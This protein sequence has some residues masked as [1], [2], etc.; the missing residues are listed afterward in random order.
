MCNLVSNNIH[1]Y[2]AINNQHSAEKTS[3]TPTSP[4]DE[5]ESIFIPLEIVLHIFSFLSMYDLNNK[6]SLVCKKW[7][8]LF[9]ESFEIWKKFLPKEFVVKQERDYREVCLN[10]LSIGNNLKTKDY[11]YR[12]MICPFGGFYTCMF[13][14]KDKIFLGSNKGFVSIIDTQS[15]HLISSVCVKNDEPIQAIAICED[16]LVVAT[17]EKKFFAAEKERDTIGSM[18]HSVRGALHFFSISKMDEPLYVT[19]FD[20]VVD[21]IKIHYFQTAE[22]KTTAI[23]AVHT[24]QTLNTTQTREDLFLFNINGY[25]LSTDREGNPTPCFKKVSSIYLYGSLLFCI[26]EHEDYKYLSCISIKNT[27]NFFIL[28]TLVNK[29]LPNNITTETLIWINSLDDINVGGYESDITSMTHNGIKKSFIYKINLEELLEKKDFPTCPI[30]IPG[31]LSKIIHFSK[32]QEM[33]LTEHSDC[34][35]LNNSQYQIIF[36][37]NKKI[38]AW[39]LDTYTYLNIKPRVGLADGKIFVLGSKHPTQHVDESLAL[40]CYDFKDNR[41][42]DRLA[43]Q[44]NWL[45]G[46]LSFISYL[47]H[48]KKW[49]ISGPLVLASLYFSSVK[50]CFSLTHQYNLNHYAHFGMTIGLCTGLTLLGYI[51]ALSTRLIYDKKYPA[52]NTVI[53]AMC[54][55]PLVFLRS[56]SSFAKPYMN[57]IT[58]EFFVESLNSYL[59]WNIEKIREENKEISLSIRELELSTKQFENQI[60]SISRVSIRNPI[61]FNGQWFERSYLLEFLEYSLMI[62]GK[63]PS[64]INQSDDTG[65]KEQIEKSRTFTSKVEK[66]EN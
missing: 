11:S 9:S 30:T 57:F 51:Y 54:T 35:K 1:D 33:F 47:L 2:F 46:Q 16:R 20:H 5:T 7:K 56:R 34:R 15:M 65:L 37:K 24:R 38:T 29:L 32:Q 66:K 26:R 53:K 22:L 17:I 12:R 60:C 14:Y 44:I 31:N 49:A 6:A 27:D 4:L 59:L 8:Q 43:S 3:I 41:H 18:Y 40:D 52:S 55:L 62:S 39:N 58:Q 28:D 13:T 45:R 19:P 21:S 36:L 63:Y 42:L 48:E 64:P 50:L 61:K 23:I 10:W 25:P